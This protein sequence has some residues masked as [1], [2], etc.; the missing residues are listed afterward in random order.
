[1]HLLLLVD[2]CV[3]VVAIVIITTAT[4]SVTIT[5]A[6]VVIVVVSS[7]TSTQRQLSIGQHC[8]PSTISRDLGFILGG[9]FC[10]NFFQYWY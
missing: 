3:C 5:V 2:C 10:Y 6:V 7:G 1:L 9:I 8:F 4:A